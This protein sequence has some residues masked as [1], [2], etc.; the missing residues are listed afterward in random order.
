MAYEIARSRIRPRRGLRGALVVVGL[1]LFVCCVGAAGLAAWNFQAVRQA[2]GPA[3]RAAGTFLDKVTAG[4]HAGAYDRLCAATRKQWS[5][6]RFAS[7][8]ET[9]PTISRYA[10]E[11]VKIASK[12]GRQ[13]ATV[14]VALTRTSGAVDNH[15]LPVVDSDDGW[16]VCGDPF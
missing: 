11:D 13:S 16:Q 12:D 8:I 2:T 4:D 5:L 7:R 15:Q 3:K 10:I 6:P 1:T 14:T 9:P